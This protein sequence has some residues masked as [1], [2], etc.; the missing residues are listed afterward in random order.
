MCHYFLQEILE[1]K[2]GSSADNMNLE[3]RDTSDQ[4][5]INMAND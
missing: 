3:L 2:F 1:R 4:F 5:L